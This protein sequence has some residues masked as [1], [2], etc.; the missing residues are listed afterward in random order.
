MYELQ[1]IH[2]N[3]LRHICARTKSHQVRIRKVVVTGILPE[4]QHTISVPVKRH[5]VQ[6]RRRWRCRG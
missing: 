2:M 3:G 6:E 5:F 4:H 1:V